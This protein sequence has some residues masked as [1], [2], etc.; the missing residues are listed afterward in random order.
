MKRKPRRIPISLRWMKSCRYTGGIVMKKFM[1]EVT[2]TLA[3]GS[4]CWNS[5]TLTPCGGQS[6]STTECTTP[7]KGGGPRPTAGLRQWVDHFLLDPV[8]SVLSLHLSSSC[9]IWGLNLL[10]ATLTQPSTVCSFRCHQASDSERV[11]MLEIGYTGNSL[12]SF[13]KFYFFLF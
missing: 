3:G 7:D 9:D 4:T 1:P 11:K 2:S 6:L 12:S 8:K 5:T 13:T 10:S